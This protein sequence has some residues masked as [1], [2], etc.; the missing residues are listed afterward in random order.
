MARGGSIVTLFAL[1]LALSSI[2]GIT[3]NLAGEAEALSAHAP[4]CIEGDED[5]TSANGVT[6]GVGTAEDPYVI[7]GWIIN[8]S[9]GHGVRIQEFTPR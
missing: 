7:E 5:F 4:I 8:A 2:A 6:S 1:C 9:E 3:G